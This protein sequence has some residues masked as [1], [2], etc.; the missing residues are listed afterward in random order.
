MPKRDSVPT[1]KDVAQEAGVAI[2]TVSKVIN[3]I[4]V[5]ESS[6]PCGGSGQKAG[7]TGSIPMPGE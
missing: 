1:I 4:S 7:L 3:G 2:A 6:H 5:G